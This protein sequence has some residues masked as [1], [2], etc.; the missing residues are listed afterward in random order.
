MADGIELPIE[1]LREMLDYDPATGALVW[2]ARPREHFHDLRAWS[3]WLAQFVGKPAG[4]RQGGY[5]RLNI[6]LDGVRHQISAHRAIWALVNNRWPPHDL[7]HRNGDRTDNRLSNLR[8]ATRAENVQNLRPTPTLGSWFDART[9]RFAA[10]ISVNRKRTFL[11]RFKT[12]EEARAAYLAAKAMLHP[13]QP[14]PRELS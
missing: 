8:E 4:T 14:V 10:M 6:T 5:V 11:G 9:D 13:F 1:K 3:T 7:D 12:R 2:K